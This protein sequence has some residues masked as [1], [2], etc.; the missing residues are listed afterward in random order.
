MDRV[1]KHEFLDPW[2]VT[3]PLAVFPEFPRLGQG[4]S[5][6]FLHH[7]L[8]CLHSIYHIESTFDMT[9]SSLDYKFLQGNSIW[10]SPLF[11]IGPAWVNPLFLVKSDWLL[12]LSLSKKATPQTKT[13]KPPQVFAHLTVLSFCRAPSSVG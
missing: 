6:V 1:H 3:K 8:Q 2:R 5:S 10:G 9:V 7:L 13:P 12:S 11:P 4:P